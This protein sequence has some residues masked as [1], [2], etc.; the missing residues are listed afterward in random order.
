EPV[1]T[2][3]RPTLTR[4]TSGASQARWR[5]TERILRSSAR[6]RSIMSTPRRRRCRCG[7][8]EGKG[9]RS[10]GRAPSPARSLL[11]RRLGLGGLALGRGHHHETLARAAV[12]ALAAV[13]GRLA[14]A[15]ALAGVHTFALD[16]R[17]SSALLGVGGTGHPRHEQRRG[18]RGDERTSSLHRTLLCGF[19]G[20]ALD[21]RCEPERVT[22]RVIDLAGATRWIESTITPFPAEDGERHVLV[23][24]RDVSQ[25]RE[26]EHRLRESRERFQLIAENA[27]DMIVEYD[28][29]WKL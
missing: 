7:A 23:V 14:V 5:E 25:A 13:L 9:R 11:V 24:S 28:S 15:V 1:R 4:A 21:R 2:K 20:A 12:L 10:S 19:A 6:S 3:T 26:L 22:F 29:D 27:Y 16:L 17:R 8:A 18:G